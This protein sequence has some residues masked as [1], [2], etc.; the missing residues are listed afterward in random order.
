MN[1]GVS[2]QRFAV[3]LTAVVG[4]LSLVT[5]VANLAS[6]TRFLL[7][8]QFIPDILRNTVALT[9]AFTGFAMLVSAWGLRRR[10]RVAWYSAVVLFPVTALQGIVQSSV[11]SFPLIILS[12]AALPTVILNRGAF[13]RRTA[14]SPAQSAAAVVLVGVLT[15][16]T[17]GTF[18]LR[19]DFP[20]VNTPLDAF[21]YTIVTSSTVG[22]GD[23]V[24]Q[25]QLAETFTLSLIVVGTA[26]FALV[27]A[28]LITPAIEAR[29]IGALGR[30]TESQLELLTD[31]V[32]VL[33][34]GDLTE[35]IVEELEGQVEF[36]I[37][38]DDGDQAQR[39][40]ERGFNTLVA[41]PSDEETLEKAHIESAV[42][43]VVA[44]NND[45]EDSLSV[46][47]ARQLNPDIRIV[48]AATEI[49]N[50][51]KLRRAGA[52][53]VVSPASIAGHLLVESALGRGEAEDAAEKLL[54]E[55]L[56]T[57]EDRG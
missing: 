22:Y 31:H 40:G 25:T 30:M 6:T 20:R 11:L 52:D 18:A 14:L 27:I 53:N 23:I 8:A 29:L 56:P 15:Y 47:T 12:V 54:E 35:P 51:E 10:L 3:T 44:T 26:G 39:L 42:A 34:Y 19:N 2:G 7:I 24:P 50:I 4:V 21:Y 55:E 13:D 32:I 57:D 43:A 36:L 28:A 49:E 41:D 5:G 46:L 48:A 17:V 16:G 37:I 45:A 33:G 9:G 1:R 38:T